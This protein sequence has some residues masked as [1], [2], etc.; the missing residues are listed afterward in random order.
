[1]AHYTFIPHVECRYCGGPMCGIMDVRVRKFCLDCGGDVEP[2][3]KEHTK[4]L[5]DSV[6]SRFR[7]R[8]NP[9]KM[10]SLSGG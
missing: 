7:V 10:A 5:R 9:E 2:E 6:P 8:K 3:W 4:N 1:M